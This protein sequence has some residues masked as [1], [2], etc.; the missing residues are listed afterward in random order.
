MTVRQQ[1]AFALH[2]DH[3]DALIAELLAVTDLEALQDQRPAS[4]SGGQQQRVALARALV[5]QPRILLLDEPLSALDAAMR[6][7]LQGYLAELQ[8]RW[9]MTTILVSH[10]AAEIQLL[11]RRVAELG[12]GR[13]LREAPAA[14]FFRAAPPL[15]LRGK[16]EALRE[17]D[18]Q[19]HLTLVLPPG[20]APS[21]REGDEVRVRG[22]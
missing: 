4:L 12:Q 1:L 15:E 3:N 2:P 9:R 18:G 13:I 8:Q 10:D 6:S 14:D 11:A 20:E 7:T 17:Q 22:E 19:W 21:L 5:Q 16:V